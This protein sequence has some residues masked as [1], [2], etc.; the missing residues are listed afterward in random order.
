M[1]YIESP[2][3]N[4][5]FNLALEQYIF[6]HMDK[7]QEYFMLWQNN[8]TVV[9][10]KNQNAFSEVNHKTAAEKHIS[11]IRRLSGGGAVYHDLGNLNFTFI[12]NAKNATDLDI[13]LFCQPIA[14]LLQSLNVPAEI[15][16]RND[17]TIDGKKFSGNSQYLKQGRIMHHGTLMFNSD[18]SIISNVLN[19]SA[20]KFQ[21]KA[22]KSVKSRVTNIAPYLPDGFTLEAFKFLLLKHILKTDVIEPY[23]FSDKDLERIEQIKKDRYDKWDWNYGYSPSYHVEKSRRFEGC[24]KISIFMNTK[25]GFISDIK[26]FGDFF[27]IRD[28]HLL[29]NYLAGA[30]LERDDLKKHLSTQKI[31]QYFHGL[32]LEDFLDLLLQSE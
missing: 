4:P 16:G 28:T 12:V 7:N 2:S 24:G 13:R 26:F 6:E 1:L 30:K 29:E 14:E 18:L 3:T 17:I 22:A 32:N 10:G 11:V 23:K 8:N 20:D 27:G 25:D 31:E 9:I 21:S 15:N 5:A 19:V